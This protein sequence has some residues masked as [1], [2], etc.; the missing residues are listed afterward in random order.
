MIVGLDSLDNLAKGGRSGR[1]SAFVGGVLNM[2]VM[3]TVVDDGAFI[4]IARARGGKAA[5]QASVDWVSE[6]VSATK[7]AAFGVLHCASPEK[8]AWLEDALRSRFHVADL[9][10]IETGLVIATHAGTG[11]GLTGAELE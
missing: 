8:A 6:Y 7:R 1:V 3:L 9:A 11:W 5:L 2:R 10:I 4:P